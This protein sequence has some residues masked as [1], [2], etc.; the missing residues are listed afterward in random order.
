MR[1]S[2]LFIK[3]HGRANQLVRLASPRWSSSSTSLDQSQGL[4]RCQW[5]N[6]ARMQRALSNQACHASLA[7]LLIPYYVPFARVFR[8]IPFL[9]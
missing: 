8:S 7:N 2:H 4:Q 5:V 3:Y 9:G 1:L 6:C